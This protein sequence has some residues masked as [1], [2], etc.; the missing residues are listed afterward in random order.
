[1]ELIL[2]TAR[3]DKLKEL[4]T[5]RDMVLLWI[6]EFGNNAN[7]KASTKAL[8]R[9]VLDHLIN[10]ISA[11]LTN[12]KQ[13]ITKFDAEDKVICGIALEMLT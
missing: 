8:A 10:F 1:M 12:N 11:Y 9:I 2:T 6:S 13:L 3:F 5:R 7:L 4:E